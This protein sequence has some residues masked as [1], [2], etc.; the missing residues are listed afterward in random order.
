METEQLALDPATVVEGCRAILSDG[1]KGF[2]L[3]STDD[4]RPHAPEVDAPSTRP[5]GGWVAALPVLPLCSQLFAPHRPSPL[6]TPP[7]AHPSPPR[8]YIVATDAK[9]G[10]V[11]GQ[12][13][14]E[15]DRSAPTPDSHTNPPPFQLTR[16]SRSL[17][18][19]HS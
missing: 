4:V 6:L 12:V 19:I 9:L 14:I 7:C 8:F 11:V 17:V 18:R 3:I 16:A 13:G 1:T 10:D 15:L 2:V 5:G